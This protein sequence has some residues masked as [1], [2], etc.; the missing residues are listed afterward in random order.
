ML[1]FHDAGDFARDE[2]EREKKFYAA[3]RVLLAKGITQVESVKR[4][5]RFVLD[6]IDAVDERLRRRDAAERKTS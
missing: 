6:W 1:C 5:R 2:R 3:E 4:A